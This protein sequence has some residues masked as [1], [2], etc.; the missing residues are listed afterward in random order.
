MQAI[1]FF[2]AMN[3]EKRDKKTKIPDK[4]PRKNHI[5]KKNKLDKT[6]LLHL[7]DFLTNCNSYKTSS[8]EVQILFFFDKQAMRFF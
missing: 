5:L 4:E 6:T 2:T 1:N 8:N 7:Q 3:L